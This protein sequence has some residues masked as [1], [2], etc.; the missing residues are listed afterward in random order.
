M[1]KRVGLILCISGILLLMNPSLEMD[2]LI[3]MF[4]FVLV[5][6][7]PTGLVMIGLSLL[8]HKSKPR[9]NKN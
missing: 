1:R 6:Y 9:R 7:W 5:H 2:D 3:A 4:N 8:N